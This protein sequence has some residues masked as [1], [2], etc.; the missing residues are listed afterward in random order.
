MRNDWGRCMIDSQLDFR[1][2]SVLV[3]GDVMLDQYWLGDA[4]RISPE[5]PVPV[6]KINQQEQRLGGAANAALNAK[7]LGG[8]VSLL[9]IVGNDNN[10]QQ[11]AELL[12]Q[13]G[14]NNHN[15]VCEKSGTIAKLRLISR[16]QQML[17]ADFETTFSS[18][19][20]TNATE[21]ALGLISQHQVILLS[22][23]NKGCLSHC[24]R[25]I[26]EANK[27][28]KKVL[29]DPKGTDF[30]KYQG[31]F[32]LTPNMAEFEAVVGPCATEQQLF[33]KAKKLVNDYQL[34]AL[35]LTRS[36]QGMTLFLKDGKHQHFNAHAK[37]VFDVTGAGDTVIAT[38]AS[39]LSVG[40]EL[41]D[42]VHLANTAAGI[43][44]SKMGAATVSPLE[45]KL[46]LHNNQAQSHGIID[47]DSLSWQVAFEQSLGKKIVFTN[48]CFDILHRGHVQYLNEA[49]ALG[50]RLIVA[51]NDDQSVKRLKGDSRPINTIDDRLAVLCSLQAVDWVISFSDDTPEALLSA[52]KPD[53]LVKGGDYDVAGV[54]GGE[55]VK[56]YGGEVNV[57]SLQK[58]KSTTKIIDSIQAKK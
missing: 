55:I 56:S 53:I 10:A 13:Q 1:E 38:L 46:A 9:G 49:R 54:V 27:Q 4:S 28:G 37:E 57:L 32:L 29:V 45:L 8:N 22:D 52:I 35:L 34:Q 17:R 15:Q 42:A 43:A 20:I 50:D 21:K 11:M 31:A 58:G 40:V 5:A 48:G 16:S 6:V 18:V 7:T 33:D 41:S 30:A 26:T 23:Y 3:V 12:Q 19:A 47:I 2:N 24:Q 25:L 36:E 39:A 14:I 51:V 44:V